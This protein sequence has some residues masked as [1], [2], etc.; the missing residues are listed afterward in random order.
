MTGLGKRQLLDLARRLS[1][2]DLELVA[3]V[4]RFRLM[5]GEQ[6][7]RLFFHE[8]SSEAGSA[9]ISR[10]ALARLTDHGLLERL[11]RTVGGTRAG[12]SGHIYAATAAGKRLL[13]YT[14]GRGIASHR[15][16][17]EPSAGFV[18]HTLAI[19][20]LYVQLVESERAGIVELAVFETEPSC[21][22]RY[23]TTLG[24]NAI[25]KPDAHAILAAGEYEHASFVE[26]D[27]ATAARQAVLA[28]LRSYLDY[29][30]S[31]REQALADWFPR[32]VW[33]SP[34]ERRAAFIGELIRTLPALGQQLFVWGQ[35]GDALR[36]LLG[37]Q[38]S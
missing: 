16:S 15:G 14:A 13:D 5:Q 30:R 33:L 9:R 18:A 36:P 29:Y 22:R 32:V 38:R 31:G 17:Y 10:R 34:N 7:R 6:L 24:A 37:E 27:L 1:D 26:I 8:I 28:K 12:S 25:L 35:L 4:E 3:T 21:W 19:S 11:E 20:K 2:R 23:A